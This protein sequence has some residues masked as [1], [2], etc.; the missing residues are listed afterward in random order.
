MASFF[1]ISIS[2]YGFDHQHTIWN[3]ILIKQTVKI[4]SQILVN[5]K[6]IKSYELQNLGNYLQA[7]TAITKNEFLSWNKNQRLSFL[8]NAY[9]AYTVKLIID[10]YPVKSIKKIG[11]IFSSPWDKKFFR[12]LGQDMTLNHIE[13]KIIRKEF[14]ESRIHFAVNCA[15]LGC[16]SLLQEAY[17]E[18]KLNEQLD[19][20]TKHFLNNNLK[21]HL[22]NNSLYISKIFDWYGDDFSGGV[23]YFIQKYFNTSFDPQKINI[24]YLKYDWNLNDYKTP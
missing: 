7:L 6:N 23:A 24:K 19:F 8:I 16:P 1:I 2:L 14:L 22:K 11:S 5:Y 18:T 12:L 10:H 15:S 3:N 17:I 9:N 20:A 4:E 21:N 13:H